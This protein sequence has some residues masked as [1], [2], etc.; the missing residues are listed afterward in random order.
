[1]DAEV[2]KVAVQKG[3]WPVEGDLS[4]L[5]GASEVGA[6]EWSFGAHLAWRLQVGFLKP[7][8]ASTPG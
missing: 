4:I 7:M 8:A 5:K 2:G 6:P 1:M 3:T